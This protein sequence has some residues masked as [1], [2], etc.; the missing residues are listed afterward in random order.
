M[1]YCAPDMDRRA[2]VLGAAGAALAALLPAPAAAAPGGARASTILG[3]AE[4]YLG[5]PYI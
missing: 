3:S 4:S 2:F 5:V 1:R